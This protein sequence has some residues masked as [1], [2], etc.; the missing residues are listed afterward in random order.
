MSNPEL[1]EN[2]GM[3]TDQ[4]EGEMTI[5]TAKVQRSKEAEGGLYSL[6]L[7]TFAAVQ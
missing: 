2:G 4:N 7:C 1:N 5:F 3:C 6:S